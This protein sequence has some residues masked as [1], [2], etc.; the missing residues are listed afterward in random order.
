MAAASRSPK[1]ARPAVRA[2]FL[3]LAPP[4]DVVACSVEGTEYRVEDG[5]ADVREAH[6]PVLVALGWTLAPAA[7][8]SASPD[9]A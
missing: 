8:S 6:A 4:P 1:V 3:R 5:T 7:A 2:G 9:D